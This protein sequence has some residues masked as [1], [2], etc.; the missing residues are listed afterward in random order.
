MIYVIC[1]QETPKRDT[2]CAK[3]ERENTND[4]VYGVKC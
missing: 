2:V 3:K 1:S 4:G